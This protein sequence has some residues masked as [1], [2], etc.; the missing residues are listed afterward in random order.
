MILG[1]TETF[2]NQYYRHTSLHGY[3]SLYLLLYGCHD[4]NQ[5]DD[6]GQEDNDMTTTTTTTTNT[7]PGVWIH[8]CCLTRASIRP[9]KSSRLADV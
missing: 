8:C 9:E 4:E 3:H 2:T 6:E 7:G 5:E 1:S